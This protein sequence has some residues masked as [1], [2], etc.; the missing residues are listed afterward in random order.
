MESTLASPLV[1]SFIAGSVSGTCSTLLFQPLDLIKTRVQNSVILG[2]RLGMLAVATSVVKR[3]HVLGLWR[4]LVPSILR[5]VPGVG[6]YFSTLHFLRSNFGSVDPRPI[7]SIQ[8]GGISRAFA[9]VL[10]L[11][12][13]V[14]KIRY[15]SSEFAYK[16]MSRALVV[17][18][19]QEGV[20]GLYSGLAPTLMRD[21][22]FSAL[23]LMFYTQLKKSVPDYAK[24]N[25]AP[26]QH[27]A[28]GLI[29]G[30]LTSLITQPADVV[31]TH[32]QLH[33]EKYGKMHIAAIHV[34]Q[35]DGFVGFWRG[36]VPRMLRRTLMTATAWTLY[37]E[38][39]RQC[40]LK[41]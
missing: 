14:I 2:P 34:Y 6:I 20:K 15:E 25:P 32:S 41:T 40:G 36:M 23:Y 5:C 31:K 4:G 39:M 8:M 35:S 27:L 12:F 9:S 21:V 10:L 7:E 29:A 11:P 16:S 17:I 38:V 28:C 37:E 19:Q 33:P 22:P 24:Q 1:K 26:L 18:F 13:T 30:I 3:D